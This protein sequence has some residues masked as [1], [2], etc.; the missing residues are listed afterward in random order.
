MIQKINMA[1]AKG[2]LVCDSWDELE[3]LITKSTLNPFDDIW[4]N[5]KTAYPC[6]AILIHGQDACVHYFLN[7]QGDMWQAVGY[8]DRDVAFISDGE[9]SDMPADAVIPFEQA[10]VC[11]KQFFEIR[12]PQSH[13]L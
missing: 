9:K 4:L 8:G 12:L 1:N 7:D 5:G 6:L 10:L 11:A 2:D 13:W 3:M